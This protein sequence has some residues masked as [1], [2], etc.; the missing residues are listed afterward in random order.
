[1]QTGCDYNI[2]LLTGDKSVHFVK[3]CTHV[4]TNMHVHRYIKW[5]WSVR[6]LESPTASLLVG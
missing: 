1:M 2:E 6:Y 5:A 3:L 4:Y